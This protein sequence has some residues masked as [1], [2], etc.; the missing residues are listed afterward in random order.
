M[1][2]LIDE[3]ELMLIDNDAGSDGL[4]PATGVGPGWS[5]SPALAPLDGEEV[6]LAA[7]LDL[8]RERRA[9]LLVD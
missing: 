6:A 2:V 7:M 5:P 3:F 8:L 1:P 4:D 9:R